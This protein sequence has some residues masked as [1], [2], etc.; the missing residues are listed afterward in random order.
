MSRRSGDEVEKKRVKRH[1]PQDTFRG[2]VNHTLSE[3][4]KRSYAQWIQ[5]EDTLD[6]TLPTLL[7]DGYRLS[8]SMDKRSSAFMAA[9]STKDASH[10]NANLVLTARAGTHPWEAASRAMY[11]H[12][13]ILDEVWPD[14]S[15]SA[16][17]TDDWAPS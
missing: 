1:K 10:V 15:N 13:Y 7:G 3:A 14:P 6:N 11:L 9:I 8:L 4:D 12:Y 2:F 5:T 17:Y 16:E